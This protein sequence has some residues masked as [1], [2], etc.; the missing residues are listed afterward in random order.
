MTILCYGDS[1]TYGYDPRSYFGSRYP[2]ESRWVDILSKKTGLKTVNEGENGREIPRREAEFKQFQALIRQS[3][4]DGLI[5]LLGGN[6]LLQGASP[7][8]AAGR[9]EKFLSQITDIKK[10]QIVLVG[11]PPKKLGSWVPDESLIR[12]SKIL[13]SAYEDLAKKLGIRFANASE[14]DID[15]CYDG[16]HFSEKGHE[17]F[18]EKMA[19]Y[20]QKTPVFEA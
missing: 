8:T 17:T 1:N 13:G 20:L 6:D 9:M 5:V 18:A 11:P 12:S 15:L 3:Q 14:W 7:E 2:S 4:A 16:V 10:S 19:E